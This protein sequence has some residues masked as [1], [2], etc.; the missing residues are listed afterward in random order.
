LNI[1]EILNF[2]IVLLKLIS[3]ENLK[4][5]TVEAIHD[6]VNINS[7]YDSSKINKTVFGEI[8]IENIEDILNH[9]HMDIESETEKLIESTH[10]PKFIPLGFKRY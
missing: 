3:I 7:L 1:S 6:E 4:I 10:G 2:L 5:P 8:L 9:F